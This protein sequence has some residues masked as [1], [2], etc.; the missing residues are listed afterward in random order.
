MSK[1]APTPEERFAALVDDFAPDP[2]VTPPTVG[3]RQP[4]GASALKVRGKVFAML[5]GGRLTLKLPAERVAALLAS[6][7]G[8][9]FDP[10]HDGR[11]MREWVCIAPTYTGEWLPLARE[12]HDFVRS[13]R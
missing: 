10:R 12:A 4:F 1:T 5:S 3:G 7:A 8:E 2:D 13:T 9:R 11:E 6:S